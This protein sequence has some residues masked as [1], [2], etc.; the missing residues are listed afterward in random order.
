MGDYRVQPW[1]LEYRSMSSWLSSP[2][3]ASAMLCLSK[4]V[5]YEMVNN[6]KFDWHKF[7]V[8]SDFPTMNH[9]RIIPL[10]PKIWEDITKMHLY[11]LY[12]PYLDLIYFLVTNKRTWLP[13]TSLKDNWGVIDMTPCISSK[14]NID[15][16]WNR[17]NAE[18]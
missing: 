17:F 10:F 9:K 16:I 14:I 4:T 3:I 13:T 8:K 12:K 15:L 1:G 2:Y 11:Q 18:K 7:A 6:S 5:M